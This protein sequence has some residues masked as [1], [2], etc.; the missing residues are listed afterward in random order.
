M[1]SITRL[2]GIIGS[3]FIFGSCAFHSGM[4][5]SNASLSGNDFEILSIESGTAKTTHIFG[6]GGLNH[7]ALVFEAKKNMYRS[8]PLKKGQAFAN[9]SV[10]FKRSY[11]PIVRTTYVTITADLVQFG[12]IPDTTLQQGFYQFTDARDSK[13]RKTIGTYLNSGYFESNQI[14][15]VFKKKSFIPVRIINGIENQNERYNVTFL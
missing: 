15:Y 10:D 11:F 8:S 12:N 2:A 3:V 4:M 6:F 14:A 5:T 13:N 9:V 7:Q 1:K